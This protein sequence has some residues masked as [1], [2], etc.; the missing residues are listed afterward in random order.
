MEEETGAGQ[1]ID[2]DKGR[3]R[4][5]RERLSALDSGI[6]DI[7][8]NKVANLADALGKREVAQVADESIRVLIERIILIHRRVPA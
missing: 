7:S 1:R 6:A 8:R 2:R 4:K 3:Y 5:D